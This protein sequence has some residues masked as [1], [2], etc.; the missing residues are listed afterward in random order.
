MNRRKFATRLSLVAAF[1]LPGRARGQ[2]PA[3]NRGRGVNKQLSGEGPDKGNA[4]VV[5]YN[6]HGG[7]GV[8]G[9]TDSGRGVF[10]DSY[11]GIG[12][13]GRSAGKGKTQS[14][15]FGGIDLFLAYERVSAGVFGD[16][17]NAIGVIGTSNVH[18]VAGVA[19]K[20]GVGVYGVSENGTGVM[21][22]G[23]VAGTF[24]GDLQTNG[25][26]TKS[27]GSFRI[28]HPLDPADKY[29]SHSFVESPDMMNIYN[30]NTTTDAD[31]DAVVALPAYFVALNRDFRYQLTV[32]GQFA[33][34]IVAT[35]IKD[36]RFEIKT[37]KPGVEVSWQVTG[38]RQD[39]WAN[40]HRIQVEEEKRG[41]ERG[42]YLHPELFGQPAEKQLA[43]NVLKADSQSE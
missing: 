2:G 25:T 27:G 17:P 34:A 9:Q 43:F 12:V 13:Y 16:S 6:F 22:V 19:G 8:N 15:A 41:G 38:I 36:N 18:G 7:D 20:N 29:L 21:G 11:G 23:K 30:G 32:I 33:Q 40:A 39:A 4:G 3:I 26:L 28:D 31:G 5:G 1:F 35:K 37:D 14:G 42:A 24:I 10:G